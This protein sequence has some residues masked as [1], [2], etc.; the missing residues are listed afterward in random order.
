[1]HAVLLRELLMLFLLNRLHVHQ[2]RFVAHQHQDGQVFA[3]EG[4]PD[5]VQ[6]VVQ[7]LERGLVGDVID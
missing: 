4:L 5:Q 1:M 3:L 6:P 2:I 7:V